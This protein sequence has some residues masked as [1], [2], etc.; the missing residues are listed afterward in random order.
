LMPLTRPMPEVMPDMRVL[1]GSCRPWQ[2]ACLRH[3]LHRLF[4]PVVLARRGCRGGLPPRNQQVAA[5]KFE[6]IPCPGHENAV[7][8]RLR[9]ANRAIERGRVEVEARRGEVLR[10]RPALGSGAVHPSAPWVCDCCRSTRAIG[11]Q[12]GLLKQGREKGRRSSR[13]GAGAANLPLL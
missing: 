12:V 10:R 2:P 8:H 3:A 9:A 11:G 4:G 13:R 5:A 1:R 7:E 6:H